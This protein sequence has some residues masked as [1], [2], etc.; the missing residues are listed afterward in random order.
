MAALAMG[1]GRPRPNATCI[2]CHTST[3]N[4]ATA[5]RQAQTARQ[6][7]THVFLGSLSDRALH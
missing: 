4:S 7:Y 5:E 6:L 1:G 3:R 2:Q